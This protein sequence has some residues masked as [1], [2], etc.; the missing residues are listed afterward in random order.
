MAIKPRPTV[1]ICFSGY[2]RVILNYKAE[3]KS[4]FDLIRSKYDL[5]VF[6]HAWD[7]TGLV[8]SEGGKF[9]EGSYELGRYTQ[10]DEL[11]DFLSPNAFS[12]GTPFD[13][14]AD[15]LANLADVIVSSTQAHPQAIL[16]QIHS[17]YLTNQLRNHYEKEFGKSDAVLKVRF[18]IVP[19]VSSLVEIDLILEHPDIPILFAP[20]PG[21]HLHPGGGGGCL[22]CVSFFEKNFRN[23]EF[24]GRFLSFFAQHKNHSNDVCD[25]FAIS[26]SDTM[27]AYTA[28][29]P[30][31]VQIYDS[32][33]RHNVKN[34][35]DYLLDIPWGDHKIKRIFDVKSKS[36]DIE[37]SPIFIPEKFIRFY[38]TDTLVL[39][40]KSVFSV[41][42][43]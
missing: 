19:Y 17:V 11:I 24:Q 3:W 30:N 20:T 13:D 27:N 35:H 6:F 38:L 7:R 2:P 33:K 9:V 16:S 43:R 10:F 18:D 15:K 36:W 1:A 22:E 5:R 21:M 29:F 23:P 28:M 25:L 37:A 42:R 34:L 31:I 39:H 32:I 8:R 4:Y 41:R 26:N 14:Y 40:Y 12:I